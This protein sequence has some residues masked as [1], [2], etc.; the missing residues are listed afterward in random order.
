MHNRT[1]I[2]TKSI[3]K[4]RVGRECVALFDKDRAD[5]ASIEN[6]TFR[7][8]LHLADSTI[9]FGE[10]LAELESVPHLLEFLVSG[11]SLLK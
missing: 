10:L 4:R 6:A 5:D 11:M 3:S 2:R 1:Q 8:A 7:V 9:D